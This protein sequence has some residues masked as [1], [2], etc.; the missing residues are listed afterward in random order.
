MLT[1]GA[2]TKDKKNAFFSS[3][4]NTSDDR[5]KP[6]VMAVGV[7]SDV[8]DDDGT[9]V[10][11]NGTSFSCPTMCGAVACLVQAFP[12]RRPTEI[13]KALQQSADN[14]AHPDNIF[15]YGIPNVERAARILKTTPLKKG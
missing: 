3:I 15:G 5:I 11:V 14:A 10:E 8:Y 9:I 7:N 2:V 1:V 6:D 12:H 4:G 13:I